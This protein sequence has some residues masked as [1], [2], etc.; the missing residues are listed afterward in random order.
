MIAGAWPG[1][2]KQGRMSEAWSQWEGHV[3]NDSFHLSKHLGDTE[4]SAVFLTEYCGPEPQPAVIKLIAADPADAE[5]QLSRW[6][7]A[8]GLS[9]PHLLRILAT[10]RCQ[11]GTREVIFAAMEYAEENLAQILPERALTVQETHD[12]LAP[13]LDA[14]AYLHG[15]G[16]VHGHLK[17]A[18]ILAVKDQLKLAT[19]GMSRAGEKVSALEMP[20]P[21]DPP[22]LSNG[23]RSRAG[24]T[25]S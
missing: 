23:V 8:Q 14:L 6:S 3:V 18:N 13:T 15:L 4:R 16:F 20:S 19:D 2:R 11:L 25:W 7:L 9:H 12:M 10:G 17:P 5:L 24:D 1:G 22:E 21:Y